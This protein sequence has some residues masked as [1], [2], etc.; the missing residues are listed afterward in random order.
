MN[1]NGIM[2]NSTGPGGR[3]PSISGKFF[4]KDTGREI[5]V[6]DSVNDGIKMCV[7]LSDGTTMD[8]SEFQNYVQMS[9][10]EYDS[11]G[12]LIGKAKKQPKSNLDPN[13]LFAGMGDKPKE[14]TDKQSEQIRSIMKQIEEPKFIEEHN[15]EDKN[16]EEYS[17]DNQKLAMIKKILDKSSE[18]EI[19]ITINWENKPEKEFEMLKNFFDVDIEDIAY[20]IFM[21]YGDVNKIKQAFK[22]A[23]S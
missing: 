9:D 16:V 11:K 17:K 6:R 4:N 5:F 23:L 22:E 18:P 7:V 1:Q 14:T 2:I 8:M 20:A 3:G 15:V 21:Q 13:L 12:N 10:E 19:V